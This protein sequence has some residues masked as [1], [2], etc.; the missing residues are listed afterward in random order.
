MRVPLILSSLVLVCCGETTSVPD[1]GSAPSFI[2]LASDFDGF[3]KWTRF[4]L[5]RQEAGGVHVA[6][7][8]SVF[9]N[10]TPPHGSKAFPVGTVFVKLVHGDTDAGVPDQIFSMAKR[11]GTFN[12]AGAAWEWFELDLA[13][14][15]PTLVWRGALP[16]AQ[17][18]YGGGAGGACNECHS[19]TPNDFVLTSALQLGKF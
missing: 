18:G 9:V 5:G 3:D 15:P 12:A 8:R 13:T 16:P 17:K 4:D 7:E 14:Q 1:G 10:K 2:A 11:G 6:G 19:T